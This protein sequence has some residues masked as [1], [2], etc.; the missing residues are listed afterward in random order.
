MT[1]GTVNISLKEYHRFLKL[2]E[3]LNGFRKDPKTILIN[4]GGYYTEDWWIV[5]PDDAIQAITAKMTGELEALKCELKN[6]KEQQ[7]NPVKSKSSFWIFK[8]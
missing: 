3:K 8:F 4:V 5:R 7:A 1:E 6:L 2:E